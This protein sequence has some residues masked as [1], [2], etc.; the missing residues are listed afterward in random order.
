M[1]NLKLK[2]ILVILSCIPVLFVGLSVPIG[3]VVNSTT[4]PAGNNELYSQSVFPFSVGFVYGDINDDGRYIMS[5]PVGNWGVEQNQTQNGV[6]EFDFANILT[7]NIGDNS[8]TGSISYEFGERY[9]PDAQHYSNDSGGYK[10]R[11]GY[12]DM[13]LSAEVPEFLNNVTSIVFRARDIYYNPA[14]VNKFFTADYGFGPKNFMIP[15]FTLPEL[16][17]PTTQAFV[18]TYS[19][20]A[21]I[22]DGYGKQHE[23]NYSVSIDTRED[24]NVPIMFISRDALAPYVSYNATGSDI[25]SSANDT[26]IISEFTGYLDV[27][28]YV[29]TVPV[30]DSFVG[31]WVFN[32]VLSAPSFSPLVDGLYVC[33]A[34]YSYT[35]SDNIVRTYDQLVF[36]YFT[37]GQFYNMSYKNTN[38]TS[39][40]RMVYFRD[41]TSGNYMWGFWGFANVVTFYDD[42]EDESVKSW[43]ISNA[44]KRSSASTVAVEGTWEPTD[45]FV[46][47]SQIDVTVPI[48]D[49]SQSISVTPGST[50]WRWW[51]LPVA[52]KYIKTTDLFQVINESIIK[53]YTSWLVTATSGFLDAEIFPGFTIGGVMGTLIAFSVVML[54]LKLFAGG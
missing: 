47:A 6:D 40:N 18:G 5:T 23:V 53:D 46:L 45:N 7:S 1:K 24:G 31:T 48:Y 11:G 17:D 36:Q 35:T 26:I 2:R 27:Q 9:Y 3:A 14:W 54:F 32:D 20:V 51:S 10:Y 29:Y 15:T 28:Y 16:A 43:I 41:S 30:D 50:E 22:I 38:D 21:Q 12:Y 13:H 42:I 33:P 37:N 34:N 25:A 49:T 39:A 19:V 44:S 4:G 8:D 52:S